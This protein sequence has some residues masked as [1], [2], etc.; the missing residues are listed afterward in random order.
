MSTKAYGGYA[1]QSKLTVIVVLLVLFGEE[2]M[3][4]LLHIYLLVDLRDREHASRVIK[5]VP[6]NS[7]RGRSASFVSKMLSARPEDIPVVAMGH[8]CMG[9]AGRDEGINGSAGG[10][11]LDAIVPELKILLAQSSLP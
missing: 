7:I 5:C 10:R 6:H 4:G 1:G 3:C 2:S 9:R 11:D 8:S